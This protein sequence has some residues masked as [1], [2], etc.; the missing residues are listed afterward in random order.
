[1]HSIKKLASILFFVFITAAE[2]DYLLPD[3]LWVKVTFYD[4]HADGSNPNFEACNCGRKTGMIQDTLSPLRKP[5]LK[6]NIC[7]NDRIN[8]WF[9]PS[10]APES[11]FSFD[12][13]SG[14][15]KWTGLTSYLGRTN[16]WVGSQFSES[17]DMSNIV[18]YDSLPFTIFDAKTGTYE[19]VRN[20]RLNTKEQFFWLDGKG[21]GEEP[22]GK[23]HNYSFTM[24][25]HH[26]F[27]Y[28]GGEF[29]KFY[30]DDDTW[31]F[32]NGKLVLDLGGMQA[33][34][35]GTVN[36]DNLAPSLDLVKG[37]KYMFDFF[38]TERRTTQ[39][40]IVITTNILTPSK[41]N[42]IVIFPDSTTST[43]TDSLIGL[44]DTLI[45]AG[46]C[47]KLFAYVVDDTGA[48]RPD[49]S[50]NII[51]EVHDS[52]G[53][54][55]DITTRSSNNT[56]CLTEA[57]GCVSIYLS[58][59]D[60]L[61]PNIILHDT[62][63]MCVNPGPPDH[64]VIEASADSTVSLRQDNPIDVLYLSSNEAQAK[65]YAVLRDRFG[66]FAGYAQSSQ[67]TSFSTAVVQATAGNNSIGE[68]IITR[69]TNE[70]TAR[71]Q[72][73]SGSLKDTVEV[74]LENITY[75]SLRIVTGTGILRDI[76]TLRI[77]SDQDTSLTALGR[78]SDNGQWDNVL[79][80]WTA[81]GIVLQPS[82]PSWDYRWVSFSPVVADT[83]KIIISR[84]GTSGTI[85]DTVVIISSTGA[86]YTLVLYPLQGAPG[87]GNIQYPSPS[88][89]ISLTAGK[90]FPATAKLFDS[91]G[92]WL[93][94]FEN[95][96]APISWKIV[97][98][99][100]NP[101]SGE[102]NSNTGATVSYF[103][104]RAYNTFLLIAEYLGSS[105]PLTDS[106]RLYI[107][108]GAPN[109]LVI[110]GSSDRAVSPNEDF[111]LQSLVFT[112][113]DSIL[114]VYAVIRD[115]LGNFISSSSRTSWSSQDTTIATVV[116]GNS[117]IGEGV[118]QREVVSGQTSIIAVNGDDAGMLD[119]LTVMLTT[120]T[121]DSLR[122][123]VNHNGIRD[124]SFLNIYSGEDTLLFALG[125]RSDTRQW[126]NVR[127]TWSST[128][129][130]TSTTPPSMADR[131]NFSPTVPG[132]GLILITRNNVW[133][134]LRVQI[135]GASPIR[136]VLYPSTG[137][138]GLNNQP[139][140]SPPLLDTVTAGVFYPFVAKLF[141][142][143]NTWLQS[144]EKENTPIQWKI[145]KVSG[146]SQS[147]AGFL[148]NST[149]AFNNFSPVTA[150]TTVEIIAEFEYNLQVMADTV[151]LYVKPA[152]PHHLIIESSSDWWSSPNADNPIDSV[153][154]GYTDSVQYVYAVLRDTFGNF[155]DF[156]TNVVWASRDSTI[157]T[158][159]K[160]I[161]SLGEGRLIRKGTLGTG[162]IV[163]FDNA[164]RIDSTVVR[165]TNVQYDSLRIITQ[166]GDSISQLVMPTTGDT[167]LFVQGR[168][169][170]DGVW[171]Y[172]KADWQT[173]GSILVIPG[174]PSRSE[175]WHFSPADTGSGF[176]IVSM[177]VGSN[178]ISDTVSVQFN[179]GNPFSLVLYP[180]AGAPGFNNQ[181]YPNSETPV[182]IEAGAFLPLTAKLFDQSG[183]WLSNYE[184]PNQP[185]SWKI[186]EQAGFSESGNFSDSIGFF[187]MYSP[188]KAYRTVM[189]AVSFVHGTRRLTD[190]VTVS[191]IPGPAH[192]LVIEA[193]QNRE[194]SPN[195]D[196]PLNTV[197]LTSMESIRRVY[198][199]IRDKLGNWV[200]YSLIT[201]WSSN[202]SLIVN[203]QSG[204][205]S[206]GEGII[207]NVNE[208]S[209]LIRATNKETRYGST[210][211][212]DSLEV[213]VKNI[214]FIRL[215]ILNQKGFELD[216]L[217]MS[218]NDDTTLIVQGLR[219]D[220]STWENIQTQWEIDTSLEGKMAPPPPQLS[221][222]W[223]FSPASPV[224]G[225]I[226][227]TL[228]ID[229]ITIPDTIRFMAIRGE[230]VSVTFEILTPQEK[231]IAGDTIIGLV[232]IY[233]RNGLV[234]DEY[235]FRADSVK[236][237]ALYYDPLRNDQRV[238]PILFID[239]EK[240][241]LTYTANDAYR[242]DQCFTEGVD[243]VRFIL[244]YA[245]YDNDSLHEITVKL[246]SIAASTTP[247][248]ILPAKLDSLAILARNNI[249][250][251]TLI[252]HSPQDGVILTSV[253]FD[254]YG[255]LRG[256]EP[257]NWFTDGSL[258]PIVRATNLTRIYYESSNVIEPE[259]GYITVFSVDTSSGKLSSRIFISITGP[260]I[261]LKSAFTGDKNGNGYLDRIILEFSR[262]VVLPDSIPG[263]LIYQPG[264]I[265]ECIGMIQEKDN[266]WVIT[267]RED[268]SS[269]NLQTSW[270][271]QLFFDSFD[272]VT[273][274]HNY[275]IEDGAGP[276]ILSVVKTEENINNKRRDHVVVVFSEPVM[277][278]EGTTLKVV[279]PPE[280]LFIVWK[281]N[282]KGV[283]FP[284]DNAFAGIEY[285]KTVRKDAVEFYVSNAFDLS[286][287]HFLNINTQ[288]TK[289][290]DNTETRNPPETENR[291]VRVQV[292]NQV[293]VELIAVPN[294]SSPRFNR[295]N[296]GVLLAEHEPMARQWVLQDKGGTVLSFKIATPEDGTV[297]AYLKI[298][299]IA[300]NLV[301]SAKN[302]DL[303]SNLP[304]G[305][306]A[307]EINFYWNGSN[308]F[309]MK[310]AP[311]IYKT[312]LYINYSS[313]NYKDFKVMNMIGISK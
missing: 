163:A 97:E 298:H 124:I 136:L 143:N 113:T 297:N 191:I 56:F 101:P 73:A 307:Y 152:A 209:T 9:R 129:F 151:R 228:G 106:V 162:I 83:G 268:S 161:V 3:T 278:A 110:E 118:I 252:L 30:G 140:P 55:L 102:L 309:G 313:P 199:V 164:G 116:A 216:S 304:K 189:I 225:W 112:G 34:V 108:P 18:L 178:L 299:D 231:R 218:T 277:N 287:Q 72:A 6:E 149:G 41:P 267:L 147:V 75:T 50:R 138:P 80:R 67:W 186:I 64:L 105:I 81:S 123:V 134:T 294:P 115:S 29:F 272:E 188:V 286:S 25:L 71:V 232:K 250:L 23:G 142:S 296:A 65:V 242:L 2:S 194:I 160:G 169:K 305:L 111:P 285:L 51:W 301:A 58:F 195:S 103:A 135:D 288:G 126:E 4:F 293:P 306:S 175:T 61:F 69:N 99:D 222:Q 207:T 270:Q 279:T 263:L 280:S 211:L 144:F 261:A 92:N 20:M 172:V 237:G 141:S 63:R 257:G 33:E 256:P 156:S 120:I 182:N 38:Y 239:G 266:V 121:Y 66:N 258:H 26:E 47:L 98:I 57:Y 235:C 247:F 215:R 300:G 22:N 60:S 54:P 310:V 157:A 246:G 24:E 88:V 74:V 253:G 292:K 128:G 183:V 269:G 229:S 265:F 13:P 201:N 48:L 170:E 76:D 8:E 10:G 262:S 226:R 53:N 28:Q 233:N 100:G 249:S 155:V 5:L 210:V 19:F 200:D 219:S 158:A 312:I 284:I 205:T 251:D 130:I 7:C 174:P 236:G 206:I 107:N 260:A 153:T 44:G 1:M 94:D 137:A 245:P 11:S 180:K 145:V 264:A 255:N 125:L 223:K 198:A 241:N 46:E 119:T 146:G 154:F 271:P 221:N 89:M 187:T 15:W 14:F 114:S 291:K 240:S 282:E 254:R 68:G 308:S 148:Q 274:V 167:S 150:Y 109:H 203:V 275:I 283:F 220:D 12:R 213:I 139:Y 77:R 21:F 91:R 93:R 59:Q 31:I 131:W 303:A 212:T 276:V 171:E 214:Y 217:V 86:P 87:S 184:T 204:I 244:Y 243:T 302:D 70:G 40:N 227:V 132:Q 208:G 196:N 79:V 37:K 166:D 281:Y 224:A 176:I 177:R 173:I 52:L 32:I 290:T 90:S 42:S 39:S 289:I 96:G 295:V 117:A 197:T 159:A 238:D 179:A 202:D 248:R 122:I 190:T 85:S 27:T 133:D 36:L 259:Q 78:R 185:F 84:S 82:A 193:N 230:P 49:W 311:G 35:G 43:S 17:Y 234:P 62:I 104:R 165:L 16:E 273:G 181:P 95:S 45:R 192:H 168:R 127:V